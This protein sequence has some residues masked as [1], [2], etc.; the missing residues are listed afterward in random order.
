[1]LTQV[2][3]SKLGSVRNQTSVKEMEDWFLKGRKWTMG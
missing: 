3:K 1:M 2:K